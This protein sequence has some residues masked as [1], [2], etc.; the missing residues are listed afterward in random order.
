MRTRPSLGLPLVLIGS[1]ATAQDLTITPAQ[2]PDSQ[3]LALH[4]GGRVDRTAVGYTHQWPGVYF[5][6]A[7]Q[8]TTVTLGFD[9]P[10]NEYRLWIDGLDPI[11]VAQPGNSSIRISGLSDGPHALRLEKVTESVSEIGTFTG[12]TI[13]ANGQPGTP[14][15]RQRQIEFI[16]DSDMTGY[17]IRSDSR[18]CT[19]DQ[20]R[21]LSDTQIGYP[22][23]VGQHYDADYQINAI[24]GRGIVRNY[25]GF[26]PGIALPLVYSYSLPGTGAAYADPA[27]QPQIIFIALG[28]NDFATPL[29]ADENWGTAAALI[30]DFT[31]SFSQ[32]ITM[33]HAQQ[34]QASLLIVMPYGAVIPE[35]QTPAFTATFQSALLTTAGQIGLDQIDFLTLTDTKPEFTACDYHPSARDQRNRAAWLIDYLDA[36]PGLWAAD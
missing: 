26:D 27:W 29:H 9:D 6:T 15:Q 10:A 31:A 21:L 33:L 22:A 3:P 14:P 1:I 35:V 36:H 12:F 11:P 30:D 2:Q 4:I 25:D 8:G 13:D 32:F 24:S 34:P 17:G 5:E 20:V 23:L 16:G 28:G 19:P 7:F 18:I